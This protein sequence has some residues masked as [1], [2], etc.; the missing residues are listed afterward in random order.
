MRFSA[1]MF[2]RNGL[3]SGYTFMEAIENVLPFV[4]EFFILEGNSDDGT[5]ETLFSLAAL[6]RRI[7]IESRTPEYV[8]KRSRGGDLLGKAFEEAREACRG[9]WLV[10]VQADTVF[11]PVTMLAARDLLGRKGEDWGY[12]ALE[13]VRHQ[14]RW[15][16]QEMYRED[17]LALIFRKEGSRVVGDGINLSVPGRISK[18]LVPLFRRYPAA[19]NAWVFFENILG[20]AGSCSEIWSELSGEVREGDSSWYNKATGRSFRED[21]A[22]YRTEGRPPP[23]WS[24]RTSPYAE[25]LP[26][27]LLA[28]VG[29]RKY[30][31]AGRFLS[32]GGLYR[33]SEADISALR[34]ITRAYHLPGAAL[35]LAQD[36]LGLAYRFSPG[37]ARSGK[38][39]SRK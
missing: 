23:F 14:Y 37:R 35:A 32:G 34:S 28:L 10:Q 29:E 22:V 1:Y 2:I 6:D 16:W 36:L 9:E 19:D 18:S 25:K 8:R 12:D 20:K 17:R 5:K 31:V 21:M 30:S 39:R 3:R 15:N 27:N 24:G 7:R 26:R 13:I 4:D 11:H 33:P 38:S